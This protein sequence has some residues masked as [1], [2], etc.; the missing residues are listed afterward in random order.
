MTKLN[1]GNFKV[2]FR[3]GLQANINATATKNTA[4]EGEPHYTTDSDVLYVFDGTVNKQAGMRFTSTA[5]D[6]TTTEIPN[7]GEFGLHKNTTSGNVF[8]AYN[9]GGTIKKVQLA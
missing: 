3:R 9:D 6:P 5:A 7:S 4:T 1:R 8:L 2:L